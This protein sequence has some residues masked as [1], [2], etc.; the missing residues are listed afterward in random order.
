MD[1]DE[2]WRILRLHV[3][4]AIPL[5]E[6]VRTTGVPRRTL[7][8]WLARYRTGGYDALSDSVRLDRGV[9]RTSPDLVALVE[10]LALTRPRPSIATIHRRL[11][12]HCAGRD[13]DAPSYS[14][15]QNIVRALDPG[16]VTL[17]LDGPASYRDKHELLLRRRADQPNAVWQADHTM[18]D[19]LIVGP[20]GRPARPWLTVILDDYSRAVCGYLAF[21]GAPSA[22]N[23]ALALRQAIWH[24]VQPDWPVCGIPDVLYVDHGS[25]FTSHRLSA[26]AGALHLRIVHSAVG[27]PQGRGKIERFFGTVNTELLAGLPGHLTQRMSAPSPVLDLA[28]LDAAVLAFIGRYNTRVHRETK[29]SPVDAWIAGGWLP[30]MPDSLEQLDG[31]LLTVPASRVVQR[32][33]IRFQGLRYTSPTLAPF[34]GATVTIRYDPRDITEI[35]VFHRNTYLCT[36]VNPEHQSETISLKQIQAARNAH[37][38]ALRGQIQERIA[39]VEHPLAQEPPSE[40]VSQ[41]RRR[42]LRTYEEDQ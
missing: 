6:L 18:L 2:R 40:P 17:A 39:V 24:K 41:Q 12:E 8:R 42:R 36:A 21:L 7:T 4:D 5:A 3:D 11:V 15:V 19:I 33:G 1:A 9:R 34:V 23:T 32:D 10:A 22:A 16:M 26:T 13:A 30:R 20:D 35:R 14:T 29:Q 37:R 25:D 38:R 31:F 28:S 27:R